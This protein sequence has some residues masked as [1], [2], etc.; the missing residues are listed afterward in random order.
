M[1]FHIAVKRSRETVFEHIRDLSGYKAWLP[2]SEIF[3]EMRD[4]SE[5][6]VRVGTTYMDEGATTGMAGRVTEME[7]PRLIAFQQ[8][9]A[10]KRGIL[11]GGLTV[12]VCYTLQP[13]GSGET[14]VT[15]EAKVKIT[16]IAIVM[17]PVFIGAIRKEN[18]RILQCMKGY[19]EARVG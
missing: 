18:E 13:V 8:S 4:I 12:S 14:Q 10:F 9:M 11:R 16:G 15:R 2:V 7:P 5:Y 17:R 19:L 6:P 3:V 1:I